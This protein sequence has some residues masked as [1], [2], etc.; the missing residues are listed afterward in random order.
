MITSTMAISIKVKPMVAFHCDNL[1]YMYAAA[2]TN[3]KRCA[4]GAMNFCIVA[5]RVVNI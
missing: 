1:L 4:N 5:F 3:S 2:V